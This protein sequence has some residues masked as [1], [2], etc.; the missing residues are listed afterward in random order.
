MSKMSELK[1]LKPGD[2]VYWNDP[3]SGVCSR[4]YN[5]KFIEVTEESDIICIEDVDGS[6]L[7]CYMRELSLE[8][9]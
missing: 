1:K 3:D 4:S 9:P 7:E 8:V 5:I 2:R 6:Y